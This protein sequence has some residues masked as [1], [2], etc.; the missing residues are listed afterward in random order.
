MFPERLC[1]KE[2]LN[3]CGTRVKRR[4]EAIVFM[5]IH[6]QNGA[7]I[8]VLIYIA[9]R[10]H[11]TVNQIFVKDI[12]GLQ[13]EPDGFEFAL[14]VSGGTVDGSVTSL[15]LSKKTNSLFHGLKLREVELL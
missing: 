11:L 5:S 15:Y 10:V 8:H 4:K 12:Y 2:R 9:N 7:G 14:K 13:I 1:L 3:F 6:R